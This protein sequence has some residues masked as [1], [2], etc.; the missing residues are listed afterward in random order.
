MA[1]S[2]RSTLPAVTEEDRIL[3]PEQV[4]KTPNG[5]WAWKCHY[6]GRYACDVSLAGRYLC[7]CHG[8]STPR[9]RC[10][11]QSYLHQLNTGKALRLPGR[12]IKL[13]RYARRPGIPVQQLIDEY[14]ERQAMEH[15]YVRQ[16]AVQMIQDCQRDLRNIYQARRR[17]L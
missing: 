5:G 15:L 2:K 4:R 6:C 13:G 3:S 1:R 8:G 16:V 12:P 11:L 14:Y 17:P 7:R 9:Q 10:L